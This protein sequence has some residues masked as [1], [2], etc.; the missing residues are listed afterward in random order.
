MDVQERLDWLAKHD[1]TV[2]RFTPQPCVQLANILRRQGFAGDAA[3]VLMRR[4]DK[5][6]AEEWDRAI[7][8][9]DFSLRR[10]LT[11]YAHQYRPLLSLPF[12]WM[13][14]YGHQPAWVLLW[15]AAILGITIWF[16][17]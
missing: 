9:M 13:F 12:K 4:E 16:A 5:Q 3:R 6:R 7:T 11:A 15:I 8:A 2:S 1:A 10:E 17:Q 14:G